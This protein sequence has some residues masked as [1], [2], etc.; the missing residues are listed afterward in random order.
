MSA[1][2]RLVLTF[3]VIGGA[4]ASAWHAAEKSAAPPTGP[5][6]SAPV[7]VELFTSEGCSSCPPADQFLTEL[8][9]QGA[10]AGVNVIALS[11][12]VDYWNRQGWVDPFSSVS[13]TERQQRYSTALASDVFTPQMVVDGTSQF[14]GS[15]RQAALAAIREAA[16][17]PK[18]Q[19]TLRATNEGGRAQVH[20]ELAADAAAGGLPD[21]DVLLAI[22]ED[23]LVSNVGAGEN[24]GRQ[25]AHAAVTRSLK[26]V[27][28]LKKGQPT[29]TIETTAA[30]DSKW[31][32]ER[33]HA[34]VFV[35]SNNR[36]RIVGA[37]SAPLTAD[38]QA[39][40]ERR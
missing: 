7:V 29:A 37:A 28:H 38:R 33:L 13:F 23:G 40:L 34:V 19:V 18:V 32:A 9:A 31:T 22:T 24:K 10:L 2:A 3:V 14:V 26:S 17:A 35:Q 25:L 4:A 20:A 15:D 39:S 8:A 16:S 30:I 27:R 21:G 1:S 5:I 36:W 12:H 6:G 11:E